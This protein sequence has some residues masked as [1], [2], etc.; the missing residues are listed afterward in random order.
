MSDDF[1]AMLEA[2]IPGAGRHSPGSVDAPSLPPELGLE[3]VEVIARGGASWVLRA[4]D[5][6]LDRD[7]AVK[8]ARTDRNAAASDSLQTEALRTAALH[9]PSVLPVHRLVHARGQLC[10]EYRLAPTR[11]FDDLIGDRADLD[12]R[13][14]K[15]RLALLRGPAQALRHAHDLGIVHGDVHPGNLVLGDD[16][17]AWLVD[18]AGPDVRGRVAPPPGVDAPGQERRLT[19]RPSH[20]APEVLGGAWPGKAA[21]IYG[22]GVVAWEIIAG[23]PLRRRRPGEDLGGFI[24][25]WQVDSQQIPELP[26]GTM[27]SDD[28]KALVR[29]ALHPDPAVRLTAAD[30]CERLDATLS[31]QAE[32][33]SRHQRAEALITRAREVLSL[34]AELGSQLDDERRVVAVHAARVPGHV[35]P[36]GKHAL[37]QAQDRRDELELRRGLLWLEAV[38]QGMLAQALASDT[39]AT[40]ARARDMVAELWWTRLEDMESRGLV[41]EARLAAHEVSRFDPDRRGAVLR[42]PCHLSLSVADR[43]EHPARGARAHIQALR[44]RDRRLQPGA[45][46]TVALPLRDHELPP[47]RWLVTV[48]AD[49]FAPLHYPLNLARADKHRA[50]LR[51]FTRA[52]IGEGWVVVPAGAFILGGDGQARD[53]LPRCRPTIGDRFI[54]QTC[55]TC[56]EWLRF[57]DALPLTEAER[58]APRGRSPTGIAQPWW[59]AVDGRWQLPAGWSPDWPVVGIDSDDADAFARWTSEVSGR[60]LRL[61]TEEEWEKAARGTDG[62]WWPWGDRFDPSFAHTRDSLPGPP[63][64]GPVGAFSGDRSPC[65]CLDMCGLVSEWTSS[66]LS[67]DL[68]VVRGA[69]WRDVGE[70]GRCAARRGRRPDTCVPTLGFRLISEHP[71]TTAQQRRQA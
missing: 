3:A 60:P 51:L 40:A 48:E 17:V 28:V 19:G 47:G 53:A 9:H 38:E 57:L 26:P 67:P 70:D 37:W 22:L 49:G 45:A 43:T 32:Q 42:A 27:A 44:S 23:R 29:A 69:S 8:I 68:M 64:M 71:A 2:L 1:E 15:A 6:A 25:R 13:S 50:R 41:R 61:P 66:W 33:S 18:W 30:L 5:P 16:D 56:G 21:D 65:G 55:V 31:G 20:A 10:V 59:H 36:A 62:R 34:Y 7:V 4:H 52:E 35:P 11:T 24:A 12:G 54:R 58:R 14:Q 46:R 63:A 39:D